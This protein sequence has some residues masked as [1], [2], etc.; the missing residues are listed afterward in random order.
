[1]LF[2]QDRTDLR[3]NSPVQLVLDMQKLTN[4]FLNMWYMYV[5]SVSFSIL[6]EKPLQFANKNVFRRLLSIVLRT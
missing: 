1:M 3:T 4:L 2:S 5:L 6:E